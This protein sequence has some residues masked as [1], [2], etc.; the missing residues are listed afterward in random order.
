M[1]NRFV[2]LM[3]MTVLVLGFQNCSPFGVDPNAMG[4][5]LSFAS[6]GG[7]D[8]QPTS[9]KLDSNCMSNYEYDACLFKKNPVAQKGSALNGV[10]NQASGLDSLQ[11]YGVKLTG[12]DTSGTLSNSTI[13]V[14]T[15]RGTPVSTFAKNFRFR[16]QNDGTQQFSQLMTYYWLTRSIE[17]IEARTNYFP[18]RGKN[19]RVVVDDSIAGWSPTTNSIHLKLDDD[20]NTMALNAD[21]AIHFLGVANLHYATN[22]AINT[23]G[24]GTASKHKDCGLKTNGCCTSKLGCARAIESAVGDYFV[25][26]VFPDQPAI[27]ET[28]SNRIEGLGFCS[29]PRD[30]RT[31]ATRTAQ[32]AYD[33]CG[34]AGTGEVATMGTI[35]AS[36]WWEVRKSVGTTGA[37]DVDTLFMQH[38]PLL[39]G[40]DD[41]Q[42]AKAKIKSVDSR[43]FGG[44]YS[45]AFD[46]Q[47]AARGL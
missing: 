15:V 26:M 16:A 3:V 35:Y 22:G 2:L 43:L 36:I 7:S 17:Y 1:N 4:R 34:T 44:K 42:T 41:F 29:Q 37:S 45:P 27:G 32:A 23:L 12:L 30:L 9:D 14:E 19:I 11:V 8:L 28:W 20:G 21:L 24:G 46:A 39:T 6:T 10:G 18:A 47:F 40:G 33:A 5:S 13:R 31:S 38:L 25:G